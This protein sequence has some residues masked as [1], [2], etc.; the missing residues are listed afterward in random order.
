MKQVV[1]WFTGSFDN[2]QQ[3]AKN[4]AVPLVSLSDCRVKLTGVDSSDDVQNLYLQE[5]SPGFERDRL[6][7]FSQGNSAVTL[8]VR[9]FGNAGILSGICNR[10]ESERV[11]S[12]QN[13]VPIS[14][15]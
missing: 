8:G 12:Y 9:S 6:Y 13:V 14:C 10:P 1:Q 11:I 15:N 3:V 7:S 5:T 2:S 4:S